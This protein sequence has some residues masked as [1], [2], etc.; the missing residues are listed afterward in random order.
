[1][2]QGFLFALSIFLFIAFPIRGLYEKFIWWVYGSSCSLGHASFAGGCGLTA[3]SF[4]ILLMAQINI[5]L[6][7]SR[8]TEYANIAGTTGNWLVIWGC[9]LS[10]HLYSGMVK[11]VSMI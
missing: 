9:Q 5:S 7:A 8:L 2:R 11:C 4:T 1:M 3:S 10:V 6:V